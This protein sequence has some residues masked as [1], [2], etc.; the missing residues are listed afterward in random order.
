M[1]NAHLRKECLRDYLPNERSD[2]VL[3]SPATWEVTINQHSPETQ[4]K[5]KR[6]TPPPGTTPNTIFGIK[7]DTPLYNQGA[8]GTSALAGQAMDTARRLRQQAHQLT[9]AAAII[10][11]T[12]ALLNQFQQTADFLSNASPSQEY[13]KTLLRYYKLTPHYS[14]FPTRPAGHFYAFAGLTSR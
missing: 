12:H 6:P 9:T 8:F 5:P 14:V 4:Q 1:A 3:V 2:K 11:E 13:V 10:E 7:R